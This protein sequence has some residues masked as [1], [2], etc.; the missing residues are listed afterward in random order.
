STF[1]NTGR[2]KIAGGN[3]YIS[4][5]FTKKLNVTFNTDIRY[6]W[7]NVYVNNVPVKNNGLIVVGNL[8]AGYRFEKGM[9]LNASMTAMSR[10]ISSPQG[11]ANGYAST[12]FS[13]NKDIVKD[14]LSFSA[15][16][17]NP[18]TKYRTSSDKSIGPDFTQV[19]DSRNYFRG[20]STSLN[21]RFGKLK[22]SIKKNNRGIKNDDTG[23]GL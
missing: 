5:P 4:Q 15:A 1:Q 2:V 8:S 6:G 7:I 21:Y 20:F 9:R 22:E 16:V 13:M 14:K 18:F 11:K 19:N 23:G 17:N 12:S 3:I 10:N